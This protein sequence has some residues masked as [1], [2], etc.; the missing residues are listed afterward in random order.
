[1]SYV[2]R[3]DSMEIIHAFLD[4]M[5]EVFKGNE[6]WLYKR[7]ITSEQ[8]AKWVLEFINRSEC[9]SYAIRGIQRGQTVP[10]QFTYIPTNLGRGYYFYFICDGCDKRAKKLYL[11]KDRYH[12]YRCRTCYRLV[13]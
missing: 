6:Q 12:G 3:I 2:P 1:M 8:E 10:Q 4:E 5:A 13:Y 7:R 9:G 11:P